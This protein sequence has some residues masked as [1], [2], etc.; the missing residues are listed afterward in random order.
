MNDIF[1]CKETDMKRRE[2]RTAAMKLIFQIPFDTDTSAEERV[3][4][5]SQSG[6]ELDDFSKSLYEGVC[7]NVADIDG[8]I[9]PHLQKWS[10]ERLSKIAV[11]VLRLS[12]YELLYTDIPAQA[13]INEAVEL[14]KTFD[15]QKS[16]AFVN[17]VLGKVASENGKL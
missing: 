11:A 7:N 5:F 15:E 10:F 4:L 1:D 12:A 6:E 2:S 9:E 3:E 13:A 8:K 17:G 16:A 14:M